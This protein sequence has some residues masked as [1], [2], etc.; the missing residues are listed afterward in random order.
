MT[1]S[2]KIKYSIWELRLIFTDHVIIAWNKCWWT[3]LGRISD[4]MLLRL[5]K[6]VQKAVVGL[7][8][9]R[10]WCFDYIVSLSPSGG[11]TIT[12]S[13]RSTPLHHNY[14]VSF[15]NQIIQWEAYAKPIIPVDLSKALVAIF[16]GINDIS[17][18]STYTFP[19]N[20]A[21]DFPS[22]YTEI[23]NA[24]FEAIETIYKAGFRN[25]IFSNLPPRERT[26]F[27]SLNTVSSV[28]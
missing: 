12:D 19:R 26:V 4:R 21:T 16:I 1:R 3:E 25:D 8:L 6:K 11:S 10:V 20:N 18:S 2:F 22:F 17:D 14:S 23:V 24:E 28:C 5:T 13:R 9:R 7:C 15:Q 27:N